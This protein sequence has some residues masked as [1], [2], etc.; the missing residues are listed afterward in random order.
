MIINSSLLERLKN[1]KSFM[2]RDLAIPPTSQA[3]VLYR[4]LSIPWHVLSSGLT[5]TRP[6]NSKEADV[7]QKIDT[8]VE[9][10]GGDPMDV[11]P[12]QV[13]T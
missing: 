5:E 7:M 10:E 3:L 13:E 9:I 12:M 2:T 4:P 1:Q 11:E 8:E 6:T